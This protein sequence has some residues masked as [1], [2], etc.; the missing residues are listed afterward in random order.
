MFAGLYETE[1]FL[2]YL[3]FQGPMELVE[4][5]FA[6]RWVWGRIQWASYAVGGTSLSDLLLE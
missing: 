1:G 4:E 2:S 6:D 5:L 3:P